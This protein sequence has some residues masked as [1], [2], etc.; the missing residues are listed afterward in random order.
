MLLKFAKY[1]I[2]FLLS[3]GL[4]S[5]LN[6]P[7]MVPEPLIPTGIKKNVTVEVFSLGIIVVSNFLF[8]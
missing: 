3:H 4:G 2:G 8:L 6:H 7:V 1:C 5:P